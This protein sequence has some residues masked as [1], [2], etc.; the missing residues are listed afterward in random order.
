MG[1]D[2]A[3]QTA[4]RHEL[5]LDLPAW[6][7]YL[8]FIGHVA[9]GDLGRSFTSNRPVLDSIM[10]RFGATATLS[11]SAMLIASVLGVGI[12]VISAIRSYSLFDNATML[13]ALIELPF[14]HS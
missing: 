4:I 11:I 3:T 5:G 6:Q 10:D 7:Q 2:L 9:Q 8:R 14:P 13:F 1:A 12:G